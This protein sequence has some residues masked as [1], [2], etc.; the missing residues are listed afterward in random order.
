MNEP[1][2]IVTVRLVDQNNLVR[3]ISTVAI[4]ESGFEKVIDS[5]ERRSQTFGQSLEGVEVRRTTDP[6]EDQQLFAS[7]WNAL[8]EDRTVPYSQKFST[9]MLHYRTSNR[10]LLHT[11]RLKSILRERHTQLRNFKQQQTQ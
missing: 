4:P 9:L 10:V 6:H 3:T 1:M 11:D 2:L 8:K 7:Y 5:F